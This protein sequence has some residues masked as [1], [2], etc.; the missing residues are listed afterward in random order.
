MRERRIPPVDDAHDAFGARGAQLVVGSTPS[1]RTAT[2]SRR[3]CAPPV[4]HRPRAASRR[5][6]RPRPLRGA[7]AWPRGGSAV[8]SDVEQ[9]RRVA[10][11]PRRVGRGEDA[12]A[13]PPQRAVRG[14]VREHSAAR[15]DEARGLGRER[16]QRI[17]GL[18]RERVVGDRSAG[19]PTAVARP[20]VTSPT[21]P[22]GV[23]GM[24]EATSVVSRTAAKASS[25]A[26]SAAGAP[27]EGVDVPADAEPARGERLLRVRLAPGE[28]DR[29]RVTRSRT[30]RRPA[31]R[32]PGHD[33]HP[34]V[35]E[36]EVVADVAAVGDT[37]DHLLDHERR[38]TRRRC[39]G[40]R[41][42]VE[43]GDPGVAQEL[44]HAAE[45]TERPEASRP[46]SARYPPRHGP[47]RSDVSRRRS[48]ASPDQVEARMLALA[49]RRDRAVVRRRRRRSPSHS[50]RCVRSSSRA[51][52]DCGPR[53]A[54]ARSS[55]PAADAD[56]DIVD[57][58][59]Q[60]RS[61]SSTRSRSCT[62]TSWTA[63]TCAAAATRCTRIS[64]P[65]H[66]RG[67]ARRSHAASATAWRSSSAT[68]R[69]CTPT[70]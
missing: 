1:T 48:P 13:H 14:M 61:S 2:A 66:G 4:P 34:G 35:G 69:S 68:S 42:R 17:G 25:S 12:R 16:R 57:R 30:T 6:R 62:T 47:A 15:D 70:C 24:T 19:S 20:G 53:S 51:A 52:S 21:W 28:L 32:G 27:D 63:P 7:G 41:G 31:R 39:R 60:P 36:H 45:A 8:R 40:R 33:A 54:T 65:A 18:A 29:R 56:A 38:D 3:R 55:E 22:L 44:G 11:A 37:R 46:A 5:P 50:R 23:D 64:R 10:A 58:R 59:V 67:L 49:R 9:L 43:R 26:A